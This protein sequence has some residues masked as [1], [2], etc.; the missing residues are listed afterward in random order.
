[1]IIAH[2]TVRYQHP[3]PFPEVKKRESIMVNLDNKSYYSFLK[4]LKLIT[5]KEVY[6]RKLY[7]PKLLSILSV[8]F[9]VF[10]GGCVDVGVQTIP[11]TINYSSQLKFVNLIVGA[12]TA[13]L[14]LDGQSLG[15][16]NLGGEAP[17][18][19]GFM[20]IPSGNKVLNISYNDANAGI[21]TSF[22]ARFTAI[23]DYRIR[24]FLIGTSASNE[25]MLNAQRY[26]WQTKDS[27]NGRALFPA[28]TG[29]VAFFNG[30]PDAVLTGVDITGGTL[31]T[32]L[33]IEFESPLEM[34][35]MMPYMNLHS[36][37]YSFSISYGDSSSTTFSYDLQ[38]KGRYTVVTY[39]MEASLKN[40]VLVD[41]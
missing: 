20:Q 37:S 21:D 2:Q 1:M 28:D 6:M 4:S 32:T 13:T 41:D 33:T 3:Y 5:L 12:E 26:I 24:I 18:S 38:S 23:T 22:I 16:V 30:S 36:G 11:D 35:G 9:V 19:S 40:T 25:L 15:T 17:S 7:N 31:D 14:T 8:W 27:E 39:D 10:I 34:G 29:Q